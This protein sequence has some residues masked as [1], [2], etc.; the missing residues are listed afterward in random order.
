MSDHYYTSTELAEAA[1]HSWVESLLR[2]EVNEASFRD[3]FEKLLQ[4]GRFPDSDVGYLIA[5]S[6]LNTELASQ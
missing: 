5:P 6:C 4:S 1:A 3:L 2:P